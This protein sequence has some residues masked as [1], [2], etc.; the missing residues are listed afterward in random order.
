MQACVRSEVLCMSGVLRCVTVM[1]QCDVV[2]IC[3]LSCCCWCFC[4]CCV[5]M[6]GQVMLNGSQSMH[7]VSDEGVSVS[8]A[9]GAEVLQIRTLDAALVSPGQ[10]TPFPE[11]IQ[12]P[13]MSQG[14]H[15][16]LAN[17]VW[18]TNY[19]SCYLNSSQ[20]CCLAVAALFMFLCA[21]LMSSATPHRCCCCCRSC[22]SHTPSMTAAWRSDSAYTVEDMQL[23]TD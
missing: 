23:L 17:N 15:F 7:A 18:G 6:C 20:S 5:C 10:P 2:A 9:D 3:L 14:M 22:G 16:N 8:S 11:G 4:F 1:V 13:D 21:V 19:V 12:P